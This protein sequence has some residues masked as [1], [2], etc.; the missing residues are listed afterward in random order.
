M[1]GEA[2]QITQVIAMALPIH[3]RHRTTGEKTAIKMR[4]TFLK[5]INPRRSTPE[6]TQKLA[7]KALT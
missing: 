4:Q 3:I 1:A 5:E 6:A 7:A 2:G